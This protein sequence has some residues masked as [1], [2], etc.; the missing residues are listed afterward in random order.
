MSLIDDALAAY[1]GSQPAAEAKAAR[2][3]DKMRREFIGHA[4]AVAERILGAA[5]AGLD[6]RYTLGSE[7]PDETEE[8]TA[9]LEDGRPE[10]L[11]YRFDHSRR[12][13]TFELVQPCM[14]CENVRVNRVSDL[15]E[16][17]RL[18]ASDGDA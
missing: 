14:A 2:E 16:L 4:Q 6:W 3:F 7:L 1:N 17:G 15:S 10:Y 9:P 11:R 8:A 13:A 5:V 12:I 18:L